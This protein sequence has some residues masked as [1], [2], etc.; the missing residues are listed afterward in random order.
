M[1]EQ[2]ADPAEAAQN[3]SKKEHQLCVSAVHSL[4]GDTR[5]EAACYFDLRDVVCKTMLASPSQLHTL[6]FVFIVRLCDSSAIP[7]PRSAH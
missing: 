3:H 2:R 1:K 5:L 7:S 6:D 4:L